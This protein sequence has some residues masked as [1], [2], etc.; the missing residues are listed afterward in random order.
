[1]EPTSLLIILAGLVLGGVV[2]G[3]TGMGAP[4]VSIPIVSS[5]IG[6]PSTI[7]LLTVSYL[8]SN[9]YQIWVHAKDGL[10]G[11]G[12]LP[13]FL[14]CGILGVGFGTA[15]LVSLPV[16]W[17]SLAL[18]A[19]LFVY[20]LARLVNRDRMNLGPAAARRL[21]PVAGAAAGLLHGA[22]GIS[23]PIGGAFLQAMNMTRSQYMLALSSMLLLF[24]LAQAISLLASGMIDIS[25]L[26]AGC[27]AL[28]PVLGGMWVGNAF[29]ERMSHGLFDRTVTV[30]LTVVGIK[31]LWDGAVGL[32][33][34]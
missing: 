34:L 11:Q 7:G 5:V 4:L 1:M 32:L 13:G 23:S 21:A 9:I 24:S 27:L 17:A 26:A 22:T 20:C 10:P 31:L 28:L 30:L 14:V 8:V 33:G 2:K 15:V 25:L 19:L 16:Q 29:T 18:G 3:L 12:Y 6:V